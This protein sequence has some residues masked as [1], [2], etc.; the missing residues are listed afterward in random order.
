M[1]VRVYLYRGK[2]QHASLR[3]SNID[4]SKIGQCRKDGEERVGYWETLV[5][6]HPTYP[7]LPNTIGLKKI[8]CQFLFSFRVLYFIINNKFLAKFRPHILTWRTYDHPAGWQQTQF[9][10]LIIMQCKVV[11]LAVHSILH[12][13]A[14]PRKC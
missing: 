2:Y 7:T 6:W 9:T 1:V 4:M 10:L 14:F 12:Y 13:Q 5:S 8:F 3:L 11:G